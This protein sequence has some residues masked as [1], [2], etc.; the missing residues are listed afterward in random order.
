MATPS[1]PSSAIPPSSKTT[2]F[3][4]GGITATLPD[5]TSKKPT[6]TSKKPPTTSKK[7]PTTSKKIPTTSKKPPMTSK[8]PTTSKNATTT[9][10][11]PTTT[12]K[13]PPTTTPKLTSTTSGGTT[14]DHRQ[15]TLIPSEKPD[16]IKVR[17][18]GINK[19]KYDMLY[20]GPF[21]LSNFMP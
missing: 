14:P 8:N 12:S 4:T 15:T 6:T 10:N 9:S 16:Y 21:T 2:S 1:S 19:E 5:T 18:V 20:K 7:I 17:Q 13:K 11:Q 3:V